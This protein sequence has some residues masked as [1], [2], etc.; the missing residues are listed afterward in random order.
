VTDRC[1]RA[2]SSCAAGPCRR[3]AQFAAARTAPTA[4]AS[5]ARWPGPAR[6]PRGAGVQPPARRHDG[7]IVVRCRTA[8]SCSTT[9]G[10]RPA[11]HVA[12]RAGPRPAAH[13]P[14]TPTLTP[15]LEGEG[16]PATASHDAAARARPARRPRQQWRSATSARRAADERQYASR[17]GTALDDGAGRR[18]LPLRPRPGSGTVRASMSSSCPSPPESGCR[19]FQ[20]VCVAEDRQVGQPACGLSCPSASTELTRH[21]YGSPSATG[22]RSTPRRLP[23]PGSSRGARAA[24]RPAVALPGSREPPQRLRALDGRAAGQAGTALG[25]ARSRPRPSAP[26]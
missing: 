13:L 24:G 17:P 15:P 8:D 1:G 20:P 2:W 6:R 10:A 14:A 7:L 5:R 16:K 25:G 12:V 9:P 19:G 21:R 22:W 18:A 23:G 4:C 3:L 11:Q 26:G